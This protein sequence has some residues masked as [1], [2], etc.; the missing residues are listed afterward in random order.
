MFVLPGLWEKTIPS[1]SGVKTEPYLTHWG[2]V[3]HICVGNLIII[4]PDN[5]LSPGRRQAIIWTTAGIL[6]MGSRGASISEIL[7]GTQVFSFKKMHLKMS[8]AKWRPFCLG[9][10]VLK[11]TRTPADW[12]QWSTNCEWRPNERDHEL[13]FCLRLQDDST[14]EVSWGYMMNTCVVYLFKKEDQHEY[15]SF[16]VYII[17]HFLFS[18]WTGLT[19]TVSY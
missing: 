6:L 8:S 17:N 15:K 19:R 10:N 2:R 5:G 7:I 11:I 9:L 12:K 18:K 14:H 16:V 13:I 4:G 1:Y 3:T